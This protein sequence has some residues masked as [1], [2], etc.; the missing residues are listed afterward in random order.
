MPE[1]EN[2]T[3]DLEIIGDEF[4]ELTQAWK[5]TWVLIG[6]GGQAI[7]PLRIHPK[8]RPFSSKEE[9][10]AERSSQEAYKK[11]VEYVVT[12]LLLAEKLKEDMADILQ[13]LYL[14]ARFAGTHQDIWNEFLQDVI[15]R[16]LQ[17]SRKVKPGQPD[18]TLDTIVAAQREK[19]DGV[20]TF[21]LKNRT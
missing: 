4:R 11:M 12:L 17:Y 15:D 13:I 1:V 3:I 14:A 21:G 16:R 5:K 2:K 9:L 7:P 6:H 10:E 8:M 18:Q 20:V 19:I